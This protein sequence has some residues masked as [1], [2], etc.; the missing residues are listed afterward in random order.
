[1]KQPWFNQARESGSVLR[2]H[3][4]PLLFQQTI[5]QH[6]FNSAIIVME[7]M[8]GV[9]DV[10]SERVIKY[11]L[12]HD[13]AEVFSG[14]ASGK[15]KQD[16]PELKHITDKIE[17]DWF[18]A[19]SPSYVVDSMC[20]PPKEKIIAKLA[21]LLEGLHTALIEV[22]LGNSVLKS[23]VV[24]IS[25]TLW[26]KRESVNDYTLAHNFDKI[27]DWLC[28]EYKNELTLSYGG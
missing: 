4:K 23:A 20:L 15:A 18:V 13:L 27:Y 25:E 8:R 2:Y 1:M 22:R 5:A 12:H 6:S 3:S 7:L 14:D 11:I 17:H 26:E 21:D 19:N 10:N 16:Y 9:E 24:N 28:A